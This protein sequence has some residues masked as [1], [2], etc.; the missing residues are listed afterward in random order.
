M[1]RKLEAMPDIKAGEVQCRGRI[2]ALRES[3][4]KQHL[5]ASTYRGV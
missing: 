5:A 1:T 3:A 2:R 4:R